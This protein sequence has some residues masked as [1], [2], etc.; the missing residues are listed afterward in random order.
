VLDELGAVFRQELDFRLE[1]ERQRWFAAFHAGDPK[2]TVPRVVDGRSGPRVL[3]S[4]WRPGTPFDEACAAPEPERAAWIATL[5]RFVFRA[6][7]LG[8]YFNADPHPGNYA[9]GPDGHVTFYDFGCV[10]PTRPE[11]RI[12][13]QAMHRAAVAGDVQA[14]RGA[15]GRM[16]QTRGGAY[17]RIALDYMVEAFAPLFRSPYRITRSYAASLLAAFKESA[18]EA[19]KV[20]EDEFVPIPEGMLFMNRLQFGFY[21]VVARLDAE[22]DF[23]AIERA[24]LPDGAGA[25]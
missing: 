16:L 12:L 23:A 8:G 20:P 10:V 2:I 24:F 11:R 15:A 17:E 13:A 22:V 1:A 6:T 3:T 21:S 18:K 19:M 25:G 9:F 7:L 14:F 4:E 5:W